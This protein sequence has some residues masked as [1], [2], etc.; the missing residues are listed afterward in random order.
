MLARETTG[1]SR[2]AKT[3]DQFVARVRAADLTFDEILSHYCS[4]V[5]A[6]SNN[7]TEAARKLEKHRATIESRIVQSLV[8]E[9]R[10]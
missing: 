9:Y 3:L 5:F 1:Q 4:L 7:L 8:D 6:R 10:N 2:S